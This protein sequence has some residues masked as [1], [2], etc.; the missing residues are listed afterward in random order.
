[1]H[2][3]II[4][5]GKTPPDFRVPLVPDHCRILLSTYPNLVITV[6]PSPHRCYHINEYISAGCMVNEDLNSCD[7]LMGVKE[8]PIDQLIAN[9]TYFFFSHTIKQQPYNK[10][11]MQALIRLKITMIDYELLTFENGKRAV[12]FGHFAG[13]V[14]AHNGLL[15]YGLRTKKYTLKRAIDCVDYAELRAM[16]SGFL[17]PPIKIA[18]TG[19]GRVGS[20]TTEL[21]RAANVYEVTKEEFLNENFKRAVYTELRTKDLYKAKDG[22]AWDTA[23]FYAN[24][25]QYDSIFQPY[26]KV[27]D[28]MINTIYW[29]PKAPLFFSKED[30]RKPEFKIKS[31]A[32][33]TCDIDGS[34]PA[35][36]RSSTIENPIYGYDPIKEIEVSPFQENHI[37]IM[38]V[39][40]LPCELPKDA[41]LEF[42]HNLIKHIMPS[43]VNIPNDTMLERAT[44]CRNGDLTLKFNYLRSYANF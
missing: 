44:I 32:D 2:L 31:I 30:M 14:G 41:S 12:A 37:D 7:V 27:T 26:T 36:I 39:D 43:L 8:V 28:L 22:S 20:G 23:H 11:L 1:M 16:Y 24:P 3:G 33:I 4:R 15:S 10:K 40:N 21:L 18:V 5:E 19:T 17:L 9:K 13:V 25:D 29:D 38:A 35:T 34:I 42:S 6:Q